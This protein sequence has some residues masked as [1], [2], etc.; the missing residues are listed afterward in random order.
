MMTYFNEQD[1][2]RLKYEQRERLKELNAINKASRVV[3]ENKTLEETLQDICYLLPPAMQFPEYAEASIEYGGLQFTT[4]RFAKEGEFFIEASFQSFDGT[5]GKVIVQYRSEIVKEINLENLFLKEEQ[6]LIENIAVIISGYINSHRALQAMTW[7]SESSSTETLPSQGKHNFKLFQTFLQKRNDARNT[8]R[9]LMKFSVKEILLIST[10]YDAFHIVN[11]GE[12]LDVFFHNFFIREGMYFPRITGASSEEEIYD[13]LM[14]RH[15]DLIIFMITADLS[16]PLKVIAKIKTEYPYIPIYVLVNS[17]QSQEELFAKTST[18]KLIDKAFIWNGETSLV[19]TMV[20]LLEDARNL[21]EDIQRAF[22]RFILFIEDDLV[23]ASRILPQLYSILFEQISK[24]VDETVKDP[25]L[26]ILKFKT[27]PKIIHVQSYEKAIEYIDQFGDYLLTVFSDV[28]FY[29]GG[30]L[31][32]RAG[33]ELIEYLRNK[34]PELPV[35]LHSTELE[36]IHLAHRLKCV[37]IHKESEFL[38]DELKSFITYT[39]NF[40]SLT[41]RTAQGH[42]IAEAKDV[43]DFEKILRNI[44]DDS[45]E[46]HLRKNHFIHWLLARGEIELVRR[47]KDAGILSLS[48]MSEIRHGLLKILKSYREEQN[49]GRLV[50]FD[51]VEILDDNNI[52]L[53]GS[54]SI[55]G[56]GRGL[57]FLQAALSISNL[58]SSMGNVQFKVART[59]IIGTDEFEYFMRENDLL[60]I[61][62]NEDYD[63]V[64]K[65]FAKAKLSPKLEK[66]L[67]K[68]LK[69]LNKPLAI[70]SSSLFEDSMRQPF[71]GIF[72]TY[73]LPNQHEDFEERF[74]QLVLAIKLVY[75]S[76]FSP[77]SKSY[78]KSVG[79]KIEDEKMAVIIQ[80]VVGNAYEQAYWYPHI[81]G[82]AQSY[83][84]YP[85]EKMEPEDGVAVMAIGLGKYVVE[86]EKSYR[87]CPK[88]PTVSVQ[89]IKE[90]IKN[91]QTEF[92]AIDLRKKFVDILQG[93][94]S[95]LARLSIYDAERHGTLKHLASTYDPNNETLIPGLHIEG[96]RVINFANILKHGVVNLSES[97]SFLLDVFKEAIGGPVEIEYAIQLKS[98][99]EPLAEMYILQ[100]KPL[101]GHTAEVKLDF[102]GVPNEKC[103]IKAEKSM[104]HGKYSDISYLLYV[105]PE[106]F[107]KTRTELIATEIQ[108]INEKMLTE[109]KHYV[110]IGPG[111]WGT[112]D[113]FIGIPVQW[114]QISQ[115]KVIV[116]L[117]LEDFPLDAS[118]GSHFFHNLTSLNIGYVSIDPVHNK[119]FINWDLIVNQK[120]VEEL[121]YVRLVQFNS[122]FQILLDGKQRKAMIHLV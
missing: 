106:Q 48:S 52:V 87:F 38:Y 16:T 94:E 51:E 104:G 113:K 53:L 55:G 29:K 4:N 12:F 44:P 54:G 60:K 119:G 13:K 69:I 43:R 42:F 11:N 92:W 91:S 73:F 56:K 1:I 14:N 21:R 37:F 59:A 26:R 49:K 8:Y 41:F 35:V 74:R 6:D 107:D 5:K 47:I 24:V 23:H 7:L 81:A 83:N 17:R 96:P 97:I 110:L 86:G 80:D 105:K 121:D 68:L 88:Y 75:A 30:K 19:F 98:N 93:E 70:R 79:F 72:E 118:M 33:L 40:G 85:L 64:K 3:R 39:L 65:N 18:L 57:A 112:R 116:E 61:A 32:E 77:V 34:Y 114:N 108:K 102:T 67:R 95:S 36:N 109:K 115:A 15:F 58:F 25:I 84:Y 90:E 10:L 9:D 66:Q 99:P 100:I 111:R 101:L 45:I 62:L 28:K 20:K 122:K 117:G 22:V 120:T 2:E 27:R 71:A 82:T 50:P 63:E 89:T 31:E 78:F 76:V 103:I 46:Y